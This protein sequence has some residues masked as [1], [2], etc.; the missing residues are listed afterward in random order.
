MASQ[1]FQ[2]LARGWSS[3]FV[4][5][6]RC[7]ERDLIICAPFVTRAGTDLV[8]MNLS[9]RFKT[10]GRLTFLTDLSPLSVGRGATD[11]S[12]IRT[13][14]VSLAESRL[15]HLPK[16]HAKVYIADS[17]RT[18]V[19]SGNLTAGGLYNNYEYGVESQDTNF[20]NNLSGDLNAYSELGA[21]LDS[22]QLD[23]YC[24]LAARVRRAFEI[25]QIEIASESRRKFR[26]AIR[27]AEDELIRTHL[28]K[29]AIH[30]VFAKTVLYLL[31]RHATLSTEDLHPLI[32]QIHPDLCDN[33]EDRI[34]DGKRFG[35]KWKHAVRTA[36]QL[37]K[38][39]GEIELRGGKWSLHK[40]S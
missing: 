13:L 26:E 35:K 9:E 40:Q 4:D 28:G 19:S 5:L 14:T 6:I 33:R 29:G 21:C 38:R 16:L 8:L 3:R 34:I 37:L 2:T 24:E 32:E 11:P 36:Q 22:Y 27:D 25:E 15:I 10:I 39:R 7:A 18:I 17:H 20:I 1:P 12:A 30:N 23:R 31:K